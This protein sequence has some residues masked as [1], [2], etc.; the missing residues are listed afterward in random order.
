MPSESSHRVLHQKWAACLRNDNSSTNCHLEL[1]NEDGAST[2]FRGFP[3]QDTLEVED[4]QFI[5]NTWAYEVKE[6][7]LVP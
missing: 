4:M 5:C 1:R 3:E 6:S 2:P 7:K